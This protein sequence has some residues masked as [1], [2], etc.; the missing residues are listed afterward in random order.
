MKISKLAFLSDESKALCFRSWEGAII[1]RSLSL[2]QWYD[3][4]NP[5]DNQ[6]LSSNIFLG[7]DEMATLFFDNGSVSQ[8][9][10]EVPT[11][12]TAATNLSRQAHSHLVIINDYV[13]ANNIDL[14]GLVTAVTALKACIVGGWKPT[15][16]P[17]VKPDV[18]NLVCERKLTDN[19]IFCLTYRVLLKHQFSC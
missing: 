12:S 2:G 15:T 5:A 7:E 14:S 3:L 19:D 16:L 4:P 17:Q 8:S 9:A 18:L 11:E 10:A 6:E 13:E 1:A